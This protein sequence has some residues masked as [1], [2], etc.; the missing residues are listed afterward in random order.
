MISLVNFLHPEI[1]LILQ[2]KSGINVP[3]L[4]ILNRFSFWIHLF[5]NILW[6]GEA[7]SHSSKQHTT[8]CKIHWEK[9]LWE[10]PVQ[11]LVMF[12]KTYHIMKDT[13]VQK[14][15][16]IIHE[17]HF[18]RAFENLWIFQQTAGSLIPWQSSNALINGCYLHLL[19][20]DDHLRWTP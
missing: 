5:L 9:S 15:I 1:S 13:N 6:N 12:M 4:K 10:S 7:V 16:W 20:Y 17:Q 11:S 19:V 18:E 14:G 8:W 2:T 3:N